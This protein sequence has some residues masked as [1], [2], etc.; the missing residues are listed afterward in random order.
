MQLFYMFVVFW[1]KVVALSSALFWIG[2]KFFADQI[3][4]GSPLVN[5]LWASALGFVL[6]A[7]DEVFLYPR[8]RS[9]LRHLPTVPVSQHDRPNRLHY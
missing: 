2:G 3:P 1:L 8:F 9:P 7:I 4:N 5:A 6:C